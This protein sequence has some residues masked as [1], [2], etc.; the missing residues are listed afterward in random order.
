[1]ASYRELTENFLQTRSDADF[2]AL[3]VPHE[4][5]LL[6]YLKVPAKEKLMP[7]T[8]ASFIKFVA[9]EGSKFVL[10]LLK[11]SF[12]TFICDVTCEFVTSFAFGKTMCT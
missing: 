1:M 6:L 3:F 8:V 10:V 12:N 4:E 11:S 5:V 2:T 7:V 9:P